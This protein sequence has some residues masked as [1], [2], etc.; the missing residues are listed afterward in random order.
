MIKFTEIFNLP[1]SYDLDLKRTPDSFSVREVFLNPGYV[2]SAKE[3]TVLF[4]KAQE[5]PLVD[6]LKKEVQFTEVLLNVPG[7]APSRLNIVGA[8]EYFA[9][10]VAREL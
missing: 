6:G 1:M 9:E 2:I 10:K 8:P 5:T 7:H 3:N 4:T